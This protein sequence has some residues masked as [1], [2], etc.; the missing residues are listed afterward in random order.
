MSY[1]HALPT[2]SAILMLI[3]TEMVF[4][5][6]DYKLGFLGMVYAVFNGLGTLYKGKP[7][8]DGIYVTSW[9]SIPITFSVGIF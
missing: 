1:V 7:I 5:K 3:L 9:K 8:Y 4:L 2:F 6:R